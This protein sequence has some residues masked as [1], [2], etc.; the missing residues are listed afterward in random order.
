[1]TLRCP[2]CGKGVRHFCS[3]GLSSG[4]PVWAALP[5]SL[6]GVVAW[7]RPLAGLEVVA[8]AACFICQVQT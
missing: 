1:M 5:A 8:E 4:T 3:D 2:L 7:D 6:V